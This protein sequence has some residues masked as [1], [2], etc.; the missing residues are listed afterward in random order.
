M[1]SEVHINQLEYNELLLI[2]STKIEQELKTILNKFNLNLE[3]YYKK[4]NPRVSNIKDMFN[5]AQNKNLLTR[6]TTEN[7]Y[8]DDENANDLRLV[9]EFEIEDG[10]ILKKISN[11][12]LRKG[13]KINTNDNNN[14]MNRDPSRVDNVNKYINNQEKTYFNLEYYLLYKL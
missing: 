10:D 6:N 11:N 9:S 3:N 5:K 1:L 13:S 2:N 4:E 8:F 14:P 12:N 7:I